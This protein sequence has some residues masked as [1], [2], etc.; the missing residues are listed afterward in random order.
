MRRAIFGVVALLVLG[1]GVVGA[2]A[3]LAAGAGE[4]HAGTSSSNVLPVAQIANEPPAVASGG[5]SVADELASPAA[6]VAVFG[7]AF[8]LVVLVL[9]LAGP[10]SDCPNPGS[11]CACGSCRRRE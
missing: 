9:V 10:S 5:V 11:A 1:I 4:S 6:F 3:V 7:V 8:V 2:R